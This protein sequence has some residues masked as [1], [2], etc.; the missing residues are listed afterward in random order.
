[1]DAVT[2]GITTM[3]L[4]PAAAT[5]ALVEVVG[6]MGIVT[7]ASRHVAEEIGMWVALVCLIR[8]VINSTRM[9]LSRVLFVFWCWY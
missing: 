1:M 7:G 2:D 9:I 4:L 5:N 6:E 3:R 8:R